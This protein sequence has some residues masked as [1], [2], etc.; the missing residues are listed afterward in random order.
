MAKYS[1]IEIRDRNGAVVSKSA[2]LRG[3]RRETGRHLVKVVGISELPNEEG[4]LCILF[5]NG[6]SCEFDWPDFDALKETVRRWRNL[7]GAPLKIGELSSGVVSPRNS[8][9]RPSTNA[10]TPPHNRG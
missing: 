9:L 4:R 1:Q 10:G 8:F 2:N 5:Q 7:Y 3:I 6:N